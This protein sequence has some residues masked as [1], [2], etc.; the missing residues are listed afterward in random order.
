MGLLDI[1]FP[2]RSLDRAYPLSV[3]G[4]LRGDVSRSAFGTS[5]GYVLSDGRL[6]NAVTIFTYAKENSLEKEFSY[7]AGV[8]VV[9]SDLEVGGQWS[10]TITASG[11]PRRAM[12][13]RDIF[14]TRFDDR[15][16]KVVSDTCVVD[17]GKRFAKI[18]STFPVA[19]QDLVSAK[20]GD[21]ISSLKLG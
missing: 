2:G 21:L 11:I 12:M 20:F 19:F 13:K 16:Q 18:R 10:L 1:I 15:M 14:T 6:L 8:G 9:S 3:A 7:A 4:Y 5:V 17:C